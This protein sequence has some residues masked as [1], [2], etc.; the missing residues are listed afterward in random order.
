M[1]QFRTPYSRDYHNSPLFEQFGAP[2]SMVFESEKKPLASETYHRAKKEKKCDMPKYGA[3]KKYEDDKPSS[4]CMDTASTA[5][6]TEVTISVSKK[7]EMQFMGCEWLTVDNLLTF[8]QIVVLILLIIAIM[9][10]IVC[11]VKS[12]RMQ[13]REFE[14]QMMD[15]CIPRSSY[16]V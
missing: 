14:C 8:L 13:A 2:E 12:H 6:Q 9:I 10:M 3:I 15:S 4:Y 5:K 16:L 1:D 11:A 7:E